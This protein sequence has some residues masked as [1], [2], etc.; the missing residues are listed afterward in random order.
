MY[1][2]HTLLVICSVLLIFVA[3]LRGI[4]LFNFRSLEG[5]HTII[6]NLGSI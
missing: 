4:M 2:L 5:K 1:F 3:Q 6:I